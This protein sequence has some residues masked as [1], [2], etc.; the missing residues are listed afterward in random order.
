MTEEK[1]NEITIKVCDIFS[2][3]KFYD[4]IFCKGE[5]CI[6]C[7]D[8]DTVYSLLNVIA[9]LHNELYKQVKGEYYDYMFHWANLG[10][11]GCPNDS[12]F[13]EKEGEK[14]KERTKSDTL[15]C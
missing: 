14:R 8:S 5:H 13:K 4:C 1:L 10:Y 9:S 12:M 15:P 2:G 6:D 11:G 7:V 3:A